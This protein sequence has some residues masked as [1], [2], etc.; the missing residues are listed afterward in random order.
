MPLLNVSTGSVTPNMAARCARHYSSPMLFSI[1]CLLQS[2]YSSF[3]IGEL[4]HISSLKRQ[5]NATEE[6]KDLVSIFNSSFGHVTMRH[7]NKKLNRIECVVEHINDRSKRLRIKEKYLTLM[8]K[9]ILHET[10]SKASAYKNITMRHLHWL[11]IF[12]ET[13]Q[14]TF[15]AHQIGS[16]LLMDK[17]VGNCNKNMIRP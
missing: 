17:L 1:C 7:L 9:I 16:K 5:T 4:V 13:D 14:L 2:L 8:P 11:D 6:V 15:I 3:H 12:K 10:S